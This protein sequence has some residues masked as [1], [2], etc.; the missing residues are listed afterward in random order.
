[1]AKIFILLKS[2]KM[3]MTTKLREMFKRS[4]LKI[5]KN[6]GGNSQKKNT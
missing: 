3:N 1:M 4:V 6:L 2:K 5:D